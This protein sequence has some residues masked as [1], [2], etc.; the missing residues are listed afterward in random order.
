MTVGGWRRAGRANRADAPDRPS[1]TALRAT[2]CVGGAAV[3]AI[4]MAA[5]RLLAPAF[6]TSLLVWANL[7]GIILIALTLGYSLAG[8][9][10]DRHPAGRGLY[11]ALLGAGLWSALLPLAGRGVLDLLSRGILGT[12]IS[13]ILASFAG[14]LVVIAPAVFLL[15]FV[16]PFAIRLGASDVEHTGRI[17]GS[18]GAWSTLGSIAGTFVPA[19]VTIPFFGVRATLFGCAALLILTAAWGLRRPGLL[20]GLLLPALV[21]LVVAGPLRPEP[22]LLFE[23]ESPYQFV[24]VLQKGPYTELVV[25]E[26]GGVQSVWRHGSDLTGY[27]YDAY[28]LLPFDRPGLDRRVLVVGSGGGTIMRQYQA[29]LGSRFRLRLDGVEIDPLVASLGPRYFGLPADLA[30]RVHVADGRVYLEHDRHTYDILIV[31]AYSHQLYI[32]FQLATRQFF[33][34]AADHLAPGGILAMNV[35]AL[36]RHS[37]LLLAIVRTLHAVFPFTYVA[38][39]P[40][41][42]NYLVAA[43]DRPVLPTLDVPPLLQSLARSVAAGWRPDDGSGGLLL[44]DNR[45]P[46]E[47]LTDWELWRGAEREVDGT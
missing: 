33:H 25:N 41:A 17:A 39:V 16:T 26:G 5:S 15:G 31:D 8:R 28:L 38:R 30:R 23:G 10:A 2:A 20:L 40:G 1:L 35:N 46:L 29:V 6:G 43:S 14:V 44:T 32:P 34:L 42:Y 36:S 12:P 19:F 3:M 37:P 45:A 47:F 13:V 24:Q 4:E 18:L 21:A 27:Y 11:G 22:G 7:I 9:L